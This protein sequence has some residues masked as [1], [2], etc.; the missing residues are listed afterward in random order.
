[1]LG[2]TTMA[3]TKYFLDS[4]STSSKIRICKIFSFFFLLWLMSGVQII[5][6]DRLKLPVTFSQLTQIYNN[7]NKHYSKHTREFLTLKA[8]KELP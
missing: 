5:K 3:I 2:S 8:S 4:H 7:F 1:M 6:I